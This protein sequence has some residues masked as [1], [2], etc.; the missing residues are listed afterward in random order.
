MPDLKQI[1]WRGP[2][3]PAC[4]APF[5]RAVDGYM[6]AS[7]DTEAAAR[8]HD[9]RVAAEALRGAIQVLEQMREDFEKDHRGD[10]DCRIVEGLTLAISHI[11]SR[12]DEIERDARPEPRHERHDHDQRR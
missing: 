2:D 6:A 11:S 3:V 7:F 8:A 12:A 1:E 5:A 9:A 4:P 10:D